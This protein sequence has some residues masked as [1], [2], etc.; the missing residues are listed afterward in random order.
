MSTT[1]A[2]FAEAC[3][4]QGRIC[5]V[6]GSPFSGAVLDLV[7]ED[8]L[9]G[10][11]FAALASPW[12]DVDMRKIL[13][14]AAPLRVLGALHYLA[15]SGEAPELTALYPPA[16]RQADQASLAPVITRLAARKSGFFTEFLTS[17]PQTNEVARSRCL[18]GGFLIVAAETG[19]PLRCLEIGTSAGLN[20]N[21]S[22]FR[23]QFGEAGDWGD[24]A[25][26]VRFEG[27]WTGGAPPLVAASVAERRGCDVHPIDATREAQALRL[28]A[29]VWPDQPARLA[30]LRAAIAIARAHPPILRQEDAGA[31]AAREA[32]PREGVATV[33]FHSIVWQYLAAGTKASLLETIEAAAARATR[34]APFAWLRM[35]PSPVD[36]AGMNEVRLRLWPGGEDRV[37][38]LVHPHGATVDWRTA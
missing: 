5:E 7:A 26:G 31:W 3:R 23:Y 13:A 11:P 8:T 6:F 16:A 19:L 18:V 21:W 27:G 33:L 22:R 20:Q 36:T 35:E 14:D 24:P 2:V 30:N 17:P 29:Y 9:A 12:A 37:L 34:A 32:P 38:A 25:S 10:G 4:F 1:P 15:L 28:Q